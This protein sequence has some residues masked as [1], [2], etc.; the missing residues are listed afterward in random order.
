MNSFI[1]KYKLFDNEYIDQMKEVLINY[2][3]EIQDS[4]QQYEVLLIL[5]QISGYLSQYDQS[6]IKIIQKI[7][8]K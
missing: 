8:N 1:W 6:F 5:S 3:I 4:P 7:I 2:A